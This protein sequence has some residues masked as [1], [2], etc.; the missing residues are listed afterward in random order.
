LAQCFIHCRC[1]GLR[2]GEGGLNHLV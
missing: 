2:F 1:C